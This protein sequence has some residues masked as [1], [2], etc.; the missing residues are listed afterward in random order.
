MTLGLRFLTQ[1]DQA[2]KE[3]HKVIFSLFSTFLNNRGTYHVFKIAT[4]DLGE[5]AGHHSILPG[6]KKGERLKGK[7]PSWAS[8]RGVLESSSGDS[9]GKLLIRWLMFLNSQMGPIIV[10]DF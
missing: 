9:L 4:E 5:L 6:K 1:L 8:R 10:P 2:W 7:P 3:A